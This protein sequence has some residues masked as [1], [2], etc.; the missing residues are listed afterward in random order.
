MGKIPS[1]RVAPYVQYCQRLQEL[2]SD[3]TLANTEVVIQPVRRGYA[4]TVQ[5]M[6]EHVTTPYILVYQH[7]WGFLRPVRHAR[8]TALCSL[9]CTILCFVDPRIFL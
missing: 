7:D 5:E 6:L 9:Y 1:R 3:G 4:K 8:C 2:A